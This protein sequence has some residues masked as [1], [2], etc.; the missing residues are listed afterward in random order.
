MIAKNIPIS[1]VMCVFNGE[2]YLA[3]QLNSIK[4]QTQ[5]PDEVLI[6][7]DCSTDKSREIIKDFITEHTLN[8]ELFINEENKGWRLN[9]Y[10]AI[11]QA[12][13]DIIFFADQDDIWFENK[14][15]VMATAMQRNPKILTLSGKQFLIDSN[16]EFIKE[17]THIRT[18]KKKYNFKIKKLHLYE[19]LQAIHWKNRVG[20]AT[21]IRR[22][23][24]KSLTLFERNQAFVH[25]AWALNAAAVL[26]GSYGINFPAIKYRVHESNA[27][28][29][30]Y[31][32]KCGEK[33]LGVIEEQEKYLRQLINSFS[34]LEEQLK[35]KQYKKLKK[36]HQ[37]QLRR[38]KI[39]AK[40]DF[41]SRF[42]MLKYI[43]AFIRYVGLYYGFRKLLSDIKWAHART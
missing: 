39:Y 23:L 20:C 1:V 34:G 11:L 40:G 38:F 22:E 24:L 43:F 6:F 33:Y 8:W 14:I 31:K 15:E 12:T 29:S 21:A 32:K 26:G 17:K 16:G 25:D 3:E 30:D 27:S 37:F 19:D 28:A 9:F 10:D 18:C 36:A 2:K 42:K 7:D 41:F 35:T 5:K 4:N 13:G